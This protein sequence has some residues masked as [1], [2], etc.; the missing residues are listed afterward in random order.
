MTGIRTDGAGETQWA[1]EH[2]EAASDIATEPGIH[3]G[4]V[5]VGVLGACQTN[6]TC[7]RRMA[8]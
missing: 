3:D 7:R 8:V 6:N 4:T 5:V 2:D 1:G